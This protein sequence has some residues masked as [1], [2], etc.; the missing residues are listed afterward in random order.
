MAIPDGKQS[1]F[2]SSR[3]WWV[4]A[5][6][7]TMGAV[8]LYG[9]N[10]IESTTTFVGIGPAAMVRIAGGLL[11]VCGIMLIVQA[12]KG[13]AFANQEEEGADPTGAVSHKAF[14]LALGGICL[15]LLTIVEF[16]FPLTAAV[17]FVMV[18]HAFGSRRTVFDLIV[19]AIVSC[20]AWFGFS[21]LG[22]NLGSFMPLI[23]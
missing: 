8:W 4:G 1:L 5:A 21:K 15:P 3:P 14:F 2:V 22:I 20:C 16:G 7:S 19:G 11:V 18:T 17:S 13:V 6:V 9:A 12:L 10:T 23:G